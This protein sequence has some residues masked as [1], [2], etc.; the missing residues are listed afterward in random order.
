MKQNRNWFFGILFAGFLARVL[1]AIYNYG[2]FAIDDYYRVPRKTGFSRR[3]TSKM[4]DFCKGGFALR[5]LRLHYQLV[6]KRPG[7]FKKFV[8]L[9]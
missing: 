7:K 1:T 3:E 8:E 2:Y 4:L 6:P 9:H 5:S